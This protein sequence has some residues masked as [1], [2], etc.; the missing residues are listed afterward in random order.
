[1]NTNLLNITNQTT[2]QNMS[3]NFKPALVAFIANGIIENFVFSKPFMS[4]DTIKASGLIAG[5]QFFSG[6]IA[7]TIT[8]WLP[9]AV[10]NISGTY[11]T[12]M[13]VGTGFMAV[14]YF[15]P[16]DDRNRI[17]KFLSAVGASFIAA[18][19]SPLL[20]TFNVTR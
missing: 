10:R 11:F 13:I 12:P 4:A 8:P 2:Y 6:N 17:A 1:M 3:T 9:P 16:I 15:S 14:D 19:A 18:Q 7:N 5:L 20:D